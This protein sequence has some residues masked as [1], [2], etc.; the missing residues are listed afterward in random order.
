MS[1]YAT[2]VEIP[3]EASRTAVPAGTEVLDARLAQRVLRD[4]LE[5]LTEVAPSTTFLVHSEFAVLTFSELPP[6][7]KEHSYRKD[8]ADLSVRA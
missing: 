3:D 2:T 4:V 6:S 8:T 7:P 1:L 5:S